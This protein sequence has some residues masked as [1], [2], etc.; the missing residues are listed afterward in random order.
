MRGPEGTVSAA[1]MLVRTLPP[2]GDTGAG[3]WGP[4]PATQLEALLLMPVRPLPFSHCPGVLSLDQHL[5]A[6]PGP[7]TRM[8]G[9]S[10]FGCG[11][12]WVDD[13]G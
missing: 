7:M 4:G 3:A 5:Y 9:P 13:S 2:S 11:G 10:Q 8:L 6:L 12:T 1:G